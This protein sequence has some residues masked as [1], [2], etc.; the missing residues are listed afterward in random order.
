LLGS[1]WCGAEVGLKGVGDFEDLVG[2]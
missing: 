1:F 2:V